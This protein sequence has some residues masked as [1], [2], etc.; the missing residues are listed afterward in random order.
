MKRNFLFAIIVMSASVFAQ[1]TP[2]YGIRSKV[3]EVKAFTNVTI[4]VS[5]TQTI[6]K[7][8]LV[9]RDGYI[10]AVGQNIPIPADAVTI[11]LSGY[12]LYPGF[13]EPYTEYGIEKTKRARGGWGERPQYEGN[14]VGGNAWND[15][16]HSEKDWSS[17]FTPND[18]D[19]EA[20]QQLGFTVAQSGKFDGIFRGR[21]FVVTLDDGLPNDLFL[22]ARSLHFASFDKGSSKQ[23]YPSSLMG[24]IALI[25]QTF[26]DTDWY[27]KAKAAYG[28]NRSQKMPEFNSAIEALAARPATE[29]MIF[30]STDELSLLRATRISKEF[31][32]PFLYVGSGHEYERIEEIKA[33][34]AAIILPI[35][36]PKAP[37]VKS[38]EDDAEVSLAN[39]RHWETAP[40]NPAILEKN[41]VR[42]A[43][44]TH[45]LKDKKNF[46]KNLKKAVKRGLTEQKALAALTT[47]PAS[48][49]GLTSQ[50][51]TIEKGKLAN[52]IV[53]DTNLFTAEATIYSVWIR[54]DEEELE[55]RPG[56][57][58][59]GEYSLNFGGNSYTLSLKG[60]QEK[61]S[62]EIV[63]GE[64]KAKL[65]DLSFST[66]GK[67]NFAAKLDSFGMPGVFRFSGRKNADTLLGQA[68]KP[69]QTQLSWRAVLTSKFVEEKDT[70]VD[71]TKQDEKK[72]DKPEVLLANRT[73]PNKAYGLKELPK[74]E[75]VLVKNATIWTSED[76]GI[77]ENADLLIQNGKIAGVGKG[78]TA[79]SG[80]RVIDATGKHV[81]AGIIDEH[82]HIAISQGVNEG[83]EAITAEVRIGDVLDPDDIDIYRQLSGGVTSSHLLHGSANPI[84]GQ[85][86]LIKLRWGSGS[87]EMKFAGTPATIKFALGENV[88]QSN[89]GDLNTTRYPQTRMGVE[90]MMRD[91]FQAAV[92]YKA[93]WDSYRAKPTKNMV[94]PRRDIELD[95]LSDI[96]NSK[97]FIHCH[98][99]KQ[100]EILMLMRVAESFGFKVQTF[101]HILE[102]YKVADEMA[103]HGAMASS[104][105]DWWA[106][107]FEVYDAIPYNP[108]LMTERGVI[109][110]INS[111][112]AEMA[113]RL[114]QESG[115][116]VMYG[117]MKEVDAIKMCTINPAKQLKVDDRVGSIKVGK[118]ADFVIWTANPLSVYAKVE[119][120]WVDGKKYFDTETDKQM[121]DAV[122]EEKSKLIQ[123]LLD[124]GEGEGPGDRKGYKGPKVHWH[125]DDVEDV[126]QH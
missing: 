23:E 57:D 10:E 82:S 116:S 9:I 50:I 40:S 110:S 27:T 2:E 8:T 12:R 125:C 84:G 85:L 1:T 16:I 34:G 103:K 20:L 5:P 7:G 45:G 81:T 15:A 120:T 123:K 36:F 30:F 25:R 19:A 64:K 73:F 99:Y 96:A 59:R 48:M 54:G 68:V 43:F 72:E 112:D 37:E 119:Q 55:T 53:T 78:L 101:T 94:P 93:Q 31:G 67:L 35:D 95:A 33:A 90:N 126:W 69:D 77:I 21:S 74:T 44:T 79:P 14:R 62:G 42:F 39:L 65:Q 29:P 60:E 80:V 71:S 87:E 115:K 18:D 117:G 105:A 76:A 88:K 58:I 70:T 89:W 122:R 106:Y 41:G 13:I 114:N 24:S 28:L 91:A 124:S 52:F 75:N 104:F 109:T 111:D 97:M 107:K 38:L 98:S 46:W 4:V 102:G 11:D 17:A 92:E 113:R 32:V 83:S 22:N 118:D 86:Q 49:L 6:E 61:P 121:R 108:A 56:A 66:L 47:E 63:S 100:A 51:G 3:P 26:L